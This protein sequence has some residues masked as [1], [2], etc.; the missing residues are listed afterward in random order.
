VLGRDQHGVDALRATV[1][2][3]DGDLGLAV[4]PQVRHGAG[5]AH[6]GQAL[7]EAVRQPDRQGHE[8]RRLVAGVAEHHPLVPGALGV[9]HVLATL[10]AAQLERSVDTLRDVG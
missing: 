4:G 8:I 7:G 2:V 3:D 9:Q 1:L 6:L 10:A 5:A